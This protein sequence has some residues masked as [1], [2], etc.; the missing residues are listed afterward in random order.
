MERPHHTQLEREAVKHVTVRAA[1]V[2]EGTEPSAGQLSTIL[3]F[4]NQE[5]QARMIITGLCGY[6]PNLK[7]LEKN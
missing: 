6:C 5:H 3:A 1:P 4:N 2:C 7:G